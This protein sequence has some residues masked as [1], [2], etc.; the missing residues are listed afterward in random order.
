MRSLHTVILAVALL[1]ASTVVY[2]GPRFEADLSPAQ[3]VPPP[4]PITVTIEESDI[5]VRFSDDLSEVEVE[6]EVEPSTNVVAAHFHCNRPG[7]NGPVAFGLISPGD[8]V[9][10]G[11]VAAG[12]LT[13][14]DF[15]GADCAPIIG[16]PVNNIAA[17]AFAMRD[18]LIYINVH[19]VANPPGE[20][21]GQLL[22]D[23]ES[24]DDEDDDGSGSGNGA[25]DSSAS[26]GVN[27]E[28][29]LQELRERN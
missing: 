13:N 20:F 3:E 1:I 21:R 9:F 27:D 22:E 18:G 14:D 19:T 4:D 12:T 10:D 8:F 26:D 5:E 7:A 2:S 24:D 29:G 17:L 25:N 23:D 28:G 15:S 11:D 16:R 6:L